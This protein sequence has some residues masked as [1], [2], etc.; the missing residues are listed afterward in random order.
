MKRWRDEEMW[1]E[2]MRRQPNERIQADEPDFG[3]L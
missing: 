2:K 3:P 1:L